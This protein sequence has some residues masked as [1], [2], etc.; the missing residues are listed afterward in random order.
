MKLQI[1]LIISFIFYRAIV[2]ND[3]TIM[4][5][6]LN[7]TEFSGKMYTTAITD[8]FHE[9]SNQFECT[10]MFQHRRHFLKTARNFGYGKRRS[11]ESLIQLEVT[12]LIEKIVKL[13]GK[14]F[15]P[16]NAFNIAVVNSLWTIV[17]GQRFAHTDNKLLRVVHLFNQ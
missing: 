7:L 5:E 10:A 14:A 16:A 11:L 4:R 2:L 15:Q 13:N 6:A 12:E 17:A 9:D 3:P 8:R 1:T